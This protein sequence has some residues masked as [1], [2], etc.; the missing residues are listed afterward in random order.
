MAEVARAKA[1]ATLSRLHELEDLAGQLNGEVND[2]RSQLVELQQKLLES[3]SD[4]V[5][6]SSDITPQRVLRDVLEMAFYHLKLK[7]QSFPDDYHH[8]IDFDTYHEDGEVRVTAEVD[9]RSLDE[10][11][12]FLWES[13][14][15]CCLYELD[16]ATPYTGLNG[17]SLDLLDE[18]KDKYAW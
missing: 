14:A 2:L 5:Q 10:N 6:N 7:L 3:Q 13:F 9:R 15:E 11:L 12:G 8:E 16:N 17:I 4:E 1:D 18:L